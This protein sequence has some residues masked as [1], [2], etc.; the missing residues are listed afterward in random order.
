MRHV[1]DVPR[2]AVAGIKI[3]AVARQLRCVAL[4]GEQGGRR[5]GERAGS[6]RTYSSC[7]VSANWFPRSRSLWNSLPKAERF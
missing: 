1:V 6:S 5:G 2:R 3:A 7:A 4:V